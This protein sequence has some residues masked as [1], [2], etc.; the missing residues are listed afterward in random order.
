[1]NSNSPSNNTFKTIQIIYTALIFGV[2]LFTILGYTLSGNPTFSLE[3]DITF[4]V[5]IPI[6]AMTAYVLGNLVY[7]SL[8]NKTVVNSTLNSKLTRYQSAILIRVAC[9]EAPAF[10]AIVATFMT[11]N[12]SF[13]LISLLM[14][15]LM[16]VQFPSKEKFKTAFT[17]DMKEKSELDKL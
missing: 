6:V 9:L 12:A 8:L 5:A 2:L 17:L 15:V 14:V 7:N 16:Y 3:A 10:L 11:N 4:M 1:M 13:L